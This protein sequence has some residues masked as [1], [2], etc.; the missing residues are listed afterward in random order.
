MRGSFRGVF[1]GVKIGIDNQRGFLDLQ[2]PSYKIMKSEF[3]S[4]E[5]HRKVGSSLSCMRG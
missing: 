3:R 1:E 2:R 4:Q 5:T